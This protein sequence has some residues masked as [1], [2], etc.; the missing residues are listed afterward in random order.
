MI[1]A[2]PRAVP[3]N[4]ALPSETSGTACKNQEPATAAWLTFHRYKPI[5]TGCAT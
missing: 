1:T 3:R 5:Q 4:V 2:A